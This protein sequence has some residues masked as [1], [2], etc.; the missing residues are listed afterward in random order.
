MSDGKETGNAM[1]E[2]K[3]PIGLITGLAISRGLARAVALHCAVIRAP[4]ATDTAG[5]L[6][7]AHE[8]EAFI[9]G[10]PT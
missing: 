4:L 10:R 1:G 5:V 8:F 3:A 2:A 9:M 6:R 7:T